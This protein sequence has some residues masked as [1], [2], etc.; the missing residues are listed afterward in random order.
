VREKGVNSQWKLTV[1]ISSTTSKEKEKKSFKVSWWV[2]LVDITW[3]IG[4][5]PIMCKLS[6]HLGVK[7]WSKIMRKR[8]RRTKLRSHRIHIGKKATK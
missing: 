1:N 3:R 6:Q 5:L 7:K 2:I 4:V 8:G